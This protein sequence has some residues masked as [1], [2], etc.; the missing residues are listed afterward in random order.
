MK[1][2]RTITLQGGKKVDCGVKE[3]NDLKKSLGE[4]KPKEIAY[5]TLKLIMSSDTMVKKLVKN[6]DE[7][8]KEK[9]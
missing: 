9:K 1:K 3:F 4:Q 5:N 7:I 8:F 6:L 2:K